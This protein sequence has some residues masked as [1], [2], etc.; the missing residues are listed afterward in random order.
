[1]MT[2]AERFSLRDHLNLDTLP[3]ANGELANKWS[4]SGE[5]VR[6]MLG[7]GFDTAP[8]SVILE[9]RLQ[10]VALWHLQ[11]EAASAEGFKPIPYGV[12]DLLR[13]YAEQVV[14]YRPAGVAS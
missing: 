6:A 9:A 7:S 14:G 3:N 8:A 1:M 4:A 13:P 11:R 2:L 5:I 10:L 12:A